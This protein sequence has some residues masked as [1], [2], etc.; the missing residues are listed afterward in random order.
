M[1][2]VHYTLNK[3]VFDSSIVKPAALQEFTTAL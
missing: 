3:F 2:P 1:Y